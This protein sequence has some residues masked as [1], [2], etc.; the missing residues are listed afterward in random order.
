MAFSAALASSHAGTG[1]LGHQA[2]CV[3]QQAHGSTAG[4]GWGWRWAS[5]PP[6]PLGSAETQ[7]I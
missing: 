3:P 6:A 2:A 1:A 7:H 4:P 5:C